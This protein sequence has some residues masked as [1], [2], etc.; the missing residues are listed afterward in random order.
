MSV[1][2]KAREKRETGNNFLVIFATSG[3]GGMLNAIANL[4]QLDWRFINIGIW[5]VV[6]ISIIL[7]ASGVALRQY[8]H[9]QADMLWKS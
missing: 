4:E 9:R 2:E 1:S 7:I 3:V 8:F 6:V 5:F